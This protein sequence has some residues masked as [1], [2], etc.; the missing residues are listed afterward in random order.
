MLGLMQNHPL[1]IT[2]LL[3]YAASW[4]GTR[5]IVS[6]DPNGA[7]H[8]TNWSGIAARARQVANALD[9]LDVPPGGRVATLAWNSYRH[10]ELYYGVSGSGRILHTVN[11]RLFHEQ[12]TYM[13]THAEDSYVFFD[14]LFA[15]LVQ[16]LAAHLPS[17]R[18]WIALCDQAEM[19]TL[20][21]ANLL[22]HE[23]LLAAASGSYDWPVF[24]ENTACSLC[25]TSGTTGNPKGVLY[26]HRA[27]VLHA[28]GAC[29]A[30]SFAFSA[31]DCILVVVPLFHANAW[32]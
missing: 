15:P 3:N 28:F 9:A 29:A 6:R 23:E 27:I 13:L 10:L 24:D 17:I 14:P 32:S 8:R 2:T 21:V 16:E 31:R 12:I 11:P 25:Y 18:G 7:F 26:S 20:D 22:C 19:P 1:L 30:D 4:H 5:E